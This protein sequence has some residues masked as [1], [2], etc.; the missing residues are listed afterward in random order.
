M[1]TPTDCQGRLA[2]VSPQPPHARE[3]KHLSPMNFRAGS[4]SISCF[5]FRDCLPDSSYLLSKSTLLF[6]LSIHNMSLSNHASMHPC[7]HVS[8]I[9][10]S[11]ARSPA[12]PSPG[13][14]SLDF[15]HA[16]FL[17]HVRHHFA[18]ISR[19]CF[20]FKTHCCRLLFAQHHHHNDFIDALFLVL[21]L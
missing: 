5:L 16:H 15:L 12:C 1:S 11:L 18:T 9:L 21:S 8:S 4:F 10:T 14:T 13:P 17:R 3:S 19:F 7:T 6:Y 20:K 2:D